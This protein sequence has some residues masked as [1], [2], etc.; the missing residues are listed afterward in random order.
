MI[1]YCGGP[2]N[3]TQQQLNG[4]GLLYTAKLWAQ[5]KRANFTVTNNYG[6][7]DEWE[8]QLR[9]ARAAQL[10]MMIALNRVVP[11]AQRVS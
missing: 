2:M 5:I 9:T 1:S 8:V 6:Y 4:R 11:P 10:P 7:V 3:N